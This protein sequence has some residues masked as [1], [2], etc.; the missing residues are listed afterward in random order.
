MVCYRCR[1]GFLLPSNFPSPE[2]LVQNRIVSGQLR[3]R[4]AC[5]RAAVDKTVANGDF[6]EF[7][8]YYYYYSA[9]ERL[10]GRRNGTTI[11]CRYMYTILCTRA[12]VLRKRNRMHTHTHGHARTHTRAGP[13][14]LN[15]DTSQRRARVCVCVFVMRVRAR[16]FICV[17]VRVCVCSGGARAPGAKLVVALTENPKWPG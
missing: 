2:R 4:C 17:C 5:R 10:D 11:L 15:S 1:G 16:V 12:R 14:R 9:F 6:Y 8:Y 13:V 3:G 7:F